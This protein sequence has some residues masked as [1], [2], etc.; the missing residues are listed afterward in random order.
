MAAQGHALT[1]IG[2]VESSIDEILTEATL[3]QC[4]MYGCQPCQSSTECRQ[5]QWRLKVGKLGAS[6]LK[7]CTLP[8]TTHGH[9]QNT[10]RSHIQLCEWYSTLQ[11]DPPKLDPV[12]YGFEADITNKTL[13]PSSLPPGIK[14]VPDYLMKLP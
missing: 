6:A 7:L 14:A 8:P 2:K 12:E 1:K 9:L 3:Y 11:V 5:K 10:L 4:S 13:I